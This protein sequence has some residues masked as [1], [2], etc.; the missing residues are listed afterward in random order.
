MT[1]LLSIPVEIA[2]AVAHVLFGTDEADQR[3]LAA[4]GEAQYLIT[5]GR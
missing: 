2:R 3:V 1:I 4:K 5:M